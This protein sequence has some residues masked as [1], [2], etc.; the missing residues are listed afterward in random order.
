MKFSRW[1][2]C[3]IAGLIVA[4]SSRVVAEAA[5]VAKGMTLDSIVQGAKREGKL[6]WSTNLEEHEGR[7]TGRC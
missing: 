5:E 3:A 1:L 2:V 4:A 7:S 6:S